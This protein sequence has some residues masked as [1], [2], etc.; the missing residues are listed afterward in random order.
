MIHSKS[1][2]VNWGPGIE[3]DGCKLGKGWNYGLKLVN[4]KSGWVTVSD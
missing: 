1:K 4:E 3:N 2:V